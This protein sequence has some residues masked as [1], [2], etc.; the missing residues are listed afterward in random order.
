MRQ[1]HK[2][3]IGIAAGLFC[4][5]ACEDLVGGGS[6]STPVAASSAPPTT[7]VAPLVVAPTTTAAPSIT[8]APSMT[9]STVIDG[10]T[11][12]VEGEEVRVLGIDACEK[13]TSGGRQA[14]STAQ[15]LLAGRPVVLR[16]EPGVDR[17]RYDRLLR[18][19]EVGGTDFGRSMVTYN[20]TGVYAGKNDASTSY[21]SGLRA[22]DPNGR[23]CS[24]PTSTS[25]TPSYDDDSDLDV[26]L[27]SPGDQGLP[28]GTL[29]GGYCAK[30]WWC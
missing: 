13:S 14:T 7:S 24:T 30:K 19:V 25:P 12:V 9:V 16:V 4:L 17:D 11:L 21:V 27:P 18:Y 5:V 15:S 3:W 6:S 29:T 1:A 10:D 2:V 28:D 20:H 22:A 26:D 23:A 8:A